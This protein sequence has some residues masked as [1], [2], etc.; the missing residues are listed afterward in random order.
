M[1]V[2][3]QFSLVDEQTTSIKRYGIITLSVIVVGTRLY[4]DENPTSFCQFQTTLISYLLQHSNC[5]EV[6]EET[7]FKKELKFKSME[8]N[9]EGKTIL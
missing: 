3:S 8:Q 7:I 4:V 5:R 1:L 9:E 6:N 2:D